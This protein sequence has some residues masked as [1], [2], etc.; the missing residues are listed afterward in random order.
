WGQWSGVVLSS[1][2]PD[3]AAIYGRYTAALVEVFRAFGNDPAWAAQVPQA[4]SDAGLVEV[5]TVC[6]A[7]SWR[8]G[9]AGCLL[10]VVV[11]TELRAHLIEAGASADDLDALPEVMHH[12]DT[13]VLGNLTFSTIGRRPWSADHP[14]TLS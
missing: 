7:D 12:P 5:D 4:M 9:S 13:L 2:V 14:L 11:S 3:A 1:P 6:H 10:P 8:G